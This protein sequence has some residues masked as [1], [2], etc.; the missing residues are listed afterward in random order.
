M[1]HYSGYIVHAKEFT[2]IEGIN[3]TNGWI[4]DNSKWTAK[5]L[6]EEVVQNE[7]V[8]FPEIFR[9]KLDDPLNEVTGAQIRHAHVDMLNNI[10]ILH[11]AVLASYHSLIVEICSDLPASAEINATI[12]LHKQH[13][14]E[15]FIAADRS[16][17]IQIIRSMPINHV[18]EG[19]K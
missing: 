2:N 7:A 19:S 16:K 3:V 10:S 4:V 1:K 6:T 14:S 15:L 8:H 17:L 12:Q 11:S 5:Y 9:K 13:C 18:K